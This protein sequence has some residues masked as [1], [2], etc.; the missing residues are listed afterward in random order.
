[1][2][3]KRV[4][5]TG[6]GTSGARS[7]GVSTPEQ[8]SSLGCGV[9][10]GVGAAL[11]TAGGDGPQ[12]RLFLSADVGWVW[13]APQLWRQVSQEMPHEPMDEHKRCA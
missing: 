7:P 4:Q 12:R 9:T 13:P 11:Y 3:N 2:A 1:M 5:A 6:A 8:A 10:T